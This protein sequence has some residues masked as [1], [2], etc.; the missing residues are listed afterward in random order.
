MPSKKWK[1]VTAVIVFLVIAI[2]IASLVYVSTGPERRA[3]EEAQENVSLAQEEA[4]Q[5]M[6]E[7]EKTVKTMNR[8]N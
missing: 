4:D 7:L 6:N 2:A 5:A 8:M 3:V 1:V